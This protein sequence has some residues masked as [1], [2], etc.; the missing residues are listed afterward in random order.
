MESCNTY[1]KTMHLQSKLVLIVI[2]I[3]VFKEKDFD[4]KF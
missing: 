2:W 4:V 1:K 3:D